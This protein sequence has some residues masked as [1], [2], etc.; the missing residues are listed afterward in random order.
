[1]A[2]ICWYQIRAKGEKKNLMFLYH[3]MPVYYDINM[4]SSNDDTIIFTG[5]CKW[6]LDAYCENSNDKLVI[7][8]NKFINNQNEQIG[9]IPTE[10]IYC[11]LEDKSKILNCEIEVFSEYEDYDI[12]NDEGDRPLFQHFKNGEEIVSEILS[13]SDAQKKA[14]NLFGM[15]N[16]IPNY[17]SYEEYD[18]FSNFNNYDIFPF[19]AE[20]TGSQ[21]NGAIERAEK[22]QVGDQVKLIQEIGNEEYEYSVKVENESGFLGYLPFSQMEVIEKLNETNRAEPHARITFIEPLSKRGPR[23]KK[24]LI[25]IE[26]YLEN[27]VTE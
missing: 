12:E 20:L 17:Y 26:V 22:L 24:P 27:D 10:Y 4:I 21:L 5:D 6:S 11:T 9:E 8:V 2:N 13:F 14:N 15:D 25:D 23:C 18:D 3:S 16:I 19:E 7:D 1:M